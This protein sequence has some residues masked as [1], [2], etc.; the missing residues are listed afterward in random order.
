MG[1]VEEEPVVEEEI[2][3]SENKASWLKEIQDISFWK[4]KLD[5]DLRN[6][7]QI[8]KELEKEKAQGYDDAMIQS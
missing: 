7:N 2:K 4:A 3:E 8:C 5:D 1:R 6:E